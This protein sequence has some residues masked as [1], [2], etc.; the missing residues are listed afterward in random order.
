ML[1]FYRVFRTIR[2][3]TDSTTA[4]PKVR[5]K[6]LIAQFKG[7]S[8]APSNVTPTQLADCIATDE[9]HRSLYLA[10]Q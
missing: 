8:A 5:N 9:G 6:P 2:A 10:V 3:A 7:P 1:L 4:H